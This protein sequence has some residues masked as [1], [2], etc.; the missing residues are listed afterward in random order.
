MANDLELDVYRINPPGDSIDLLE[1]L[2]EAQAR[3]YRA[4]L[5]G[6]GTGSFTLNRNSASATPDLIARGNLVKVRAPRIQTAPIGSFFLEQG[7]FTLLTKGGADKEDLKFTGRGGLGY[8]D[9]AL[10]LSTLLTLPWWPD[11]IDAPAPGAR[12]AVDVKAGT[13]RAYT[14][15]GG[16]ITG[17]V[18]FRTP[19][20][21]ATFDTR[22]T[23]L[24]PAENSKRFLVHLL[25]GDHAGI[26]FH[27][28]QAGVT[29]YLA[30][31]GS[32]G[33]GKSAVTIKLSDVGASPGAVL[34]FLFDEGQSADRPGTVS[35]IALMTADF[36]ATEDSNGDPW[37]TTDALNGLNAS[38]NEDYLSTI[39]LLLGTGVIDVVMGAD[40]DMHAY[41]RY[42]RDLTG[43][44]FGSGVV[45]FE[46]G[47]NIE[48]TLA[49]TF[50]D[51][52]IG[53]LA[54]VQGNDD[55]YTQVEL[56][57]AASRIAREIAV[58]GDSADL[59][60]L[61]A[62]GLAEL[63][64]RL[65][66]GEV[67]KFPL[68]VAKA[69]DEDPDAGLYLPGP[70][71]S[72]GDVWIGDTGTLDTGDDEPDFTE[73]D[74][75]VS[76]ITLGHDEAG[77]LTAV[78]EARAGNLAV[79]GSLG[80]NTDTADSVVVGDT[81]GECGC[82][83]FHAPDY[84]DYA[85]H[86]Y[87]GTIHDDQARFGAGEASTP[88]DE[89]AAFGTGTVY[90]YFVEFTENT[91]L[92][93]PSG[94]S[95]WFVYD[96]CFGAK[97]VSI[98]DNG[99]G[100]YTGTFTGHGVGA[101]SPMTAYLICIHN[102]VMAVEATVNFWIDPDGWIAP[103]PPP[104]P[105]SRQTVLNDRIVEAVD[106]SRRRFTGT[107]AQ[108]TGMVPHSL[109]V[110]VDGRPI[111][112]GLTEYPETGEFELDFAPKPAI[113]SS[114]AEKVTFTY[115]AGPLAEGGGLSGVVGFGARTVEVTE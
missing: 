3:N 22:Q 62:I 86:F 75:R 81:Q 5:N 98:V 105:T 20:F 19:A 23:Y 7:D 85:P 58:S 76:A 11:C 84:I 107:L 28:H 49:R 55:L 71:D 26:Y 88:A 9:R 27:P 66:R 18:N 37:T 72:N 29:E 110:E 35:P 97:Q 108:V 24:W 47:V 56:P 4:D 77:G 89:S 63:N 14:V 33:V 54:Q 10:W 80:Q 104:V 67:V 61:E 103:T 114:P 53:T 60:T 113:G 44:A 16:H 38:V 41:N 15:A 25:D 50:S 34:R 21:C 70:A 59:A 65:R 39:G 31:K 45:R 74:A 42:G 106:G 36:T 40:L 8:W 91:A 93:A 100:P 90:H 69:G 102:D 82:P 64:L 87:A 32:R 2:D 95:E 30:S 96:A 92:A 78:I 13:Y 112:A 73:A 111:I 57:D 48:D 6:T 1:T 17:F 115:D 94:W 52:I 101:C 51:R 79:V 83:P 99:T 12:G 46:R 68:R 109:T 43:G